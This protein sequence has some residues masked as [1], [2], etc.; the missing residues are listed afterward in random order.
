MGTETKYMYHFKT[1]V[2]KT[3]ATNFAP[4][5]VLSF[6]GSTGAPTAVTLDLQLGETVLHTREDYEPTANFTGAKDIDPK[7]ALENIGTMI[8]STAATPAAP[9]RVQRIKDQQLP[10]QYRGR[11]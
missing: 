7:Q 6:F 4:D 8:P 3:M 9:D 2:I 5:G 11:D 1:A 10:G